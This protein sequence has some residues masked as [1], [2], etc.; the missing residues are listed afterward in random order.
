MRLYPFFLPPNFGHLDQTLD[1]TLGLPFDMIFCRRQNIC[2]LCK[3]PILKAFYICYYPICIK[4]KKSCAVYFIEFFHFY[5]F[6][7]LED[8]RDLPPLDT[9]TSRRLVGST[10]QVTSNSELRENQ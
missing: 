7:E 5:I 9:L 10:N 1:Y 4:E 6:N 8:H 3:I 2:H